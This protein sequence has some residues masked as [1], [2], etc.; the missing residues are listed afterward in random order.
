MKTHYGI[1]F[2]AAIALPLAAG[3]QIVAGLPNAPAPVMMAQAAQSSQ[4]GSMAASKSGPGSGSLPALTRQLA[5]AM[6]IRHNPNITVGKLLALAQHQVVRE[7]RSAD[8]PNLTG[9]ITAVDAKNGSRVSA[10]YLS[11]SR[12]MEHAGAGGTLSQLIT[13]F[14]RTH[15]LILSQKLEAKAQDANALATTEDIVLAT[16]QAFYN[17]LE[18]QA[19]VKVAAQTVNTRQTTETQVSEMTRNKLKSTLDLSFA[20]VD[21]S[22][23]R[24]L[25]L[26]AQ[27]NVDSAMATLDDILGLDHSVKFHLVKTRA[28]AQSPPDQAGPLIDQALKQRPDLLA[29]TYH[30]Q[31]ATKLARSEREQMLPSIRALGTVGSVPVRT[32]QYYTSNWWGAVG[33]NLNIPIFNGF[34]YSSQAKEATYRAEADSEAARALR[35]QIVRDVRMAWLASNT[36][37]QRVSVEQQLVQEANLA[38]K[39]AQTRY[40]LGLSSIVELSQ[41][42][43]QQTQAQIGY[44]NAQY[45]YRLSLA[46][47]NYE[48]GNQP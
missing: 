3:A 39:L 2:L 18:A 10:G 13:D 46:T 8:L 9:N 19:L 34:L 42:Q 4:A 20:Q 43:L 21:L 24:L 17:A 41:A 5:E 37:W 48:T 22:R 44:T 11:A 7:A 32:D 28:T 27:N 23:G 35:D 45:Q 33:V 14:G 30:Q 15:N 36:A 6:A 12:L 16:D 29:L 47:L 31:S 40:K 38:L 25:Q 1:V 26:D